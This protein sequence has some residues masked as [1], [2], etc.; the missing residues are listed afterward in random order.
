MAR[1]RHSK[2]T[3]TAKIARF[4]VLPVIS[5]VVLALL[6]PLES[7][8][9]HTSPSC[10]PFTSEHQPQIQPQSVIVSAPGVGIGVGVGV[11]GEEEGGKV[12]GEWMGWV[13]FWDGSMY[14]C[15]LHPGRSPRS[16]KTR[17]DVEYCMWFDCSVN[18]NVA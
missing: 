16:R 11:G 15:M 18:T 17:K 13:G 8:Q 6:E 5:S 1:G 4:I 12:D 7:V 14:M 3:S 9:V 10:H 2:R